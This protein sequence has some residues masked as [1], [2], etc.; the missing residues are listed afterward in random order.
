[1]KPARLPDNES[2]RLAALR[3]FDILDTP[4]EAAFDDLTRLASELCGTPIALISLV[5]S[6]RQ[7][8]KSRVGL[9]A[10]ETPRH[11]AFCAHAIHGRDLLEVPDALEDERFSDNPLVIG[12]PHIRFYA[13]IPLVTDDGLGMGTLCVIDRAPRHLTP[14]Q[15]RAL[16]TLGQQVVRQLELRRAIRRLRESQS[17]LEQSEGLNRAVLESA[18]DAIAVIDSSGRI[19][20][21]NPAAERIF[22]YTVGEVIGRNVT[23][24]VPEPYR[25][26]HDSYLQR[27]VTTGEKKI[28][29][30]GNH[31]VEGLRKDGTRFPMELGV[32]EMRVGEQRLFAGIAR[33]ISERIQS[34]RA[35]REQARLLNR[36]QAM[37]TLGSMEMDLATRAVTCSDEQLRIFGYVAGSVQPAFKLFTDLLHP[38]DRTRVLAALEKTARENVPFEE[39]YRILR[40]DGQTRTVLSRGEVQR[41]ADGRP[42]QMVGM[43]LDITER[44]ALERMK[45]EFVSTVSHELRTPLTSLRGALGLVLGGA[46]G[47]IPARVREVLEMAGRNSE[48]LTLLVDDILDMEML[49]SGRM[50]F[51]FKVVDLVQVVRHAL[52]ANQGYAGA[53]EVS[54]TLRAALDHAQVSADEHRLSQVLANLLSNAVKYSPAGARVEVAVEGQDDCY[55]VV[56]Q[57]HGPGIPEGFHSRI[58]ERFARADGSDSRDKG[59][60]GLGLSIAKAIVERHHGHIG[61]DSRAGAGATFFFTLPAV[62]VPGVTA[63]AD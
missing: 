14:L 18:V 17:A 7:W 58:F 35:L 57:D 9:E 11:L 51:E 20:V 28:I 52:E 4:A 32:S 39:E 41:A 48:Y 56:V 22:G 54:L 26:E 13:G 40:T 24:L 53:Y 42:L 21:F 27:Y 63:G 55:R 3:E 38:E 49:E 25:V 16:T 50:E 2:A 44:K 19:Q 8:F 15:R 6:A 37:A 34:E 62:A 59:G 43:T 61:F 12:D 45:S 29:D 33:D 10:R 1:M 23:M 47:E 31:V 60:T 36:T 5:D 46:L 30:V